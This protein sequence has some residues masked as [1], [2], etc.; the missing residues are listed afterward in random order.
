M[1]DL[2]IH[3][4]IISPAEFKGREVLFPHVLRITEDDGN[5]SFQE[6]H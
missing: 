6:S 2:K 1:Q 4:T 3:A 5:G